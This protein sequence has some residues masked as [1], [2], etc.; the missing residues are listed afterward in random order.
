MP[1]SPESGGPTHLGRIVDPLAAEDLED[2]ADL[3]QGS[4][5]PVRERMLERS[6]AAA[7]ARPREDFPKARAIRTTSGPIGRRRRGGLSPW[8]RIVFGSLM[9]LAVVATLIAVVMNLNLDQNLS[10]LGKTTPSP[11]SSATSAAASPAPAPTRAPPLPPPP[12]PWR[13]EDARNDPGVRILRGTF[14]DQPFLKA[15]QAAGLDLKQAY[16][17]MVALKGQRDL[18]RCGPRHEFLALVE[19]GSGTLKAFEY[20]ENKET[21][22]QAK[23]AQNGFLV[24]TKLDLLVRREQTTGALLLGSDFAAAAK[25]GGFDPSVRSVLADALMGHESLEELTVPAT[26]RI[27]AQQ[28]TVAGAFSRYA[29]IEALELKQPNAEP[30]RLYYFRGARVKGYFDA[31][32]RSFHEGGWRKPIP[33]ALVSSPFNPKRMHPVLHKIMPHNGTDF[34]APMGEPVYASAPGTVKSLGPAGPSGNLVVLAHP[35]NIETG[36]AHLSRF[37]D[38]LKVGDKVKRLQLVGYVGSTGRSTG[39]HL[40][41]SVKKNGVFVDSATLNLDGLTTLPSDEKAAFEELRQ[42]YDAQLNAIP[43][44]ELPK[45]AAPP[46]GEAGMPKAA[47]GSEI[48]ASFDESDLGSGDT[49]PNAP[50]P[51]PAA[52]PPANSTPPRPVATATT[53]PLPAPAL[54][55]PTATS[56]TTGASVIYLDDSELQKLQAPSDDGLVAP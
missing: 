11:P 30:L 45:P 54:P 7:E 17:A 10:L 23:T 16:R 9:A 35:G 5:H 20:I 49:T 4:V 12:G 28:V 8:L 29:G 36:Y 55:S 52:A 46:K 39:P 40:H 26:L 25:A 31:K 44:P 53:P 6:R 56:R 15:L 41:F 34:G 43:V 51:P 47:S 21:V 33:G 14:K 24:G 50:G 42:K 19:R 2:V 48:T 38:G 18:N 37:A 13:I 27:V 32:G 22:F 1:T 3:P